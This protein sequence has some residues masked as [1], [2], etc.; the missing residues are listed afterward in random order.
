MEILLAVL[1]PSAILIGWWWFGRDNPG[2]T[3]E[4]VGA[5]AFSFT[6]GG[7]LLELIVS[8]A[9]GL[10]EGILEVMEV[11]RSARDGP[12]TVVIG[13]ICIAAMAWILMRINGDRISRFLIYSLL[14]LGAALITQ[15][16]DVY[17]LNGWVL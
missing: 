6:A 3:L 7:I 8:W 14:G 15:A 10:L 1:I 4:A 13:L 9:I 17:P 2:E 16:F 5:F 12:M 11:V